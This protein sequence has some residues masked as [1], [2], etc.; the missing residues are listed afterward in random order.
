LGKG[1]KKKKFGRT[2]SKKAFNR[3]RKKTKKYKSSGWKLK[4]PEIFEE[5]SYYPYIVR[6]DREEKNK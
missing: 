2:R 3:R 6:R 4:Y 1:K 5:I